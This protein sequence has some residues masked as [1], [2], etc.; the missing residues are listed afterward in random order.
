MEALTL[1]KLRTTE[2]FGEQLNLSFPINPLKMKN[3]FGR[4]GRNSYTR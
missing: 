2:H 4:K 1:E 3:Y